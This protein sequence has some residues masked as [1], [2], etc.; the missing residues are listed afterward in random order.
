LPSF[1]L[2]SCGGGGRAASLFFSFAHMIED[3]AALKRTIIPPTTSVILN[4]LSKENGYMYIV[5]NYCKLESILI[6]QQ[7]Q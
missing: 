6:V 4:S 7:V 1:F 5:A 3:R 2:Q